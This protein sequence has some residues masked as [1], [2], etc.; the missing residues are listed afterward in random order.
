MQDDTQNNIKGD[1]NKLIFAIIVIVL[2][3]AIAIGTVF[4]IK[5]K[6]DTDKTSDT[7]KTVDADQLMSQAEEAK[8]NK[9]NETA[10][11]LIKDAKQEYKSEGDANKLVNANMQLCLLEQ[12]EYC[13]LGAE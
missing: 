2:V 12:K 10:I 13:K 8:K 3:V 7:S 5:A 1:K 9:D 11:E 6:V 4:V